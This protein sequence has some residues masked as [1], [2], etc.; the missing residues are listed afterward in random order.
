M[1]WR[2]PYVEDLE[3]EFK[4]DKLRDKRVFHDLNI[5]VQDPE[6]FRRRCV[7]TL[8]D[9]GYRISLNEMTEFES[10]EF[11]N[12]FRGGRLKPIKSI[13]KG[14]KSKSIGAKY[15]AIWK[16]LLTVFVIAL[17]GYFL[18]YEELNKDLLFW[19][20]MITLPLGLM[21]FLM[22]E[23][24][25]SMAWVKM[26]G[27]YDVEGLK[28]DLRVVISADTDKDKKE[29]LNKL[30]D[31]MSYVY[32]DLARKYMKKVKPE[33]RMIKEVP[34]DKTVKVVQEITK[35]NNQMDM[36]REK[37][38]NSRV[39]EEIYKDVMRSLEKKKDKMETILDL[40]TL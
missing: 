26:V 12:F 33:D 4:T 25:K 34:Q 18:P 23:S 9:N 14:V 16:I 15:P 2:R 39:S 40:I 36:L 38:V 8:T 19:T 5:R 27:V 10:T 29:I 35:L 6:E 37:L 17:I 30:K 11:K 28:A 1:F 22:K 7:E 31:D 3:K 20:T 21:V 13:I 32:D 24:V